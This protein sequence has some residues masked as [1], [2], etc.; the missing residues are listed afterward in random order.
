MY[1]ANK[2][3]LRDGQLMARKKG[4]SDRLS[5]LKASRSSPSESRSYPGYVTNATFTRKR[6]RDRITIVGRK[7]APS[8]DGEREHVSPLESQLHVKASR[9]KIKR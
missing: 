1:E 9:V 2:S 8:A 6:L 4:T 3:R 5:L 7:I